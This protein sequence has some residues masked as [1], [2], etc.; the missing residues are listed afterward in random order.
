MH[1]KYYSQSGIKPLIS[2]HHRW[3]MGHVLQSLCRKPITL[4]IRISI[5]YFSVNCT[6][7]APLQLQYLW[8]DGNISISHTA[9]IA[10]KCNRNARQGNAN[11]MWWHYIFRC[12]HQSRGSQ[13]AHVV[14]GCLCVNGTIWMSAGKSD[15]T[16]MC[17]QWSD[18]SLFNLLVPRYV[19]IN[20]S[21]IM[22]L[23]SD[24]C[25]GT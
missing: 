10:H 17:E 23:S 5:N 14:G 2:C 11:K 6:A 20:S 3:I 15:V 24:E 1:W 4:Y 16:P 13:E 22:M 18:V 9:N 19:S 12:H 25:L 21:D 8:S 7:I